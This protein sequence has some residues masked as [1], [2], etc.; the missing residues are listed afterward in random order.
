MVTLSHPGLHDI[1]LE[2]EGKKGEKEGQRRKGREGG[3]VRKWEHIYMIARVLAC[4]N[5]CAHTHSR[6]KR[7]S[8]E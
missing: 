8:T 4:D 3:R 7:R 2:E 6:R 5:V 1:C